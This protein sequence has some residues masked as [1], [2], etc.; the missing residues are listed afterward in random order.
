MHLQ[1]FN[2]NPISTRAL[3]TTPISFWTCA[4]YHAHSTLHVHYI[5]RPLHSARA[6]ITMP[7]LLCTTT[8]TSPLHLHC[9]VFSALYVH[10]YMPTLLHVH[11]G[12]H[13]IAL[14]VRCRPTLLHC[15]CITTPTTLHVHYHA[16][17]SLHVYVHYHTH[18]IL[19]C[20]HGLSRLI[21]KSTIT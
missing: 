20:A 6:L 14:H 9:H 4:T 3:H 18:S 1:K 2:E 16:F 15:T 19:Y 11:Y 17:S 13:S 5:P 10:Y 7:T 12:V 8:P 21:F